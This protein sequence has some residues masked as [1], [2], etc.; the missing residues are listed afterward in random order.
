MQNTISITEGRK[1][2]FQIA[3]EIQKP[4]TTY[5][6]TDKGSPAAVLISPA[7]YD[8]IIETIEILSD[9]DLLNDIKSAE[10]DYKSGRTVTLDEFV[11][12]K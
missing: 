9:T 8:S 3:K 11:S 10:E 4:D 7:E 12:Q 2:L 1:R 6:L 5:V